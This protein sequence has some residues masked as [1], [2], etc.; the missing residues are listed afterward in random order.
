MALD[1]LFFTH[2]PCHLTRFR[3]FFFFNL[4]FPIGSWLWKPLQP[5]EQPN[6]TMTPCV[7]SMNDTGEFSP[8]TAS[9]TSRGHLTF[10]CCISMHWNPTLIIKRTYFVPD[11]LRSSWNNIPS[12]ES[13]VSIFKDSNLHM[14]QTSTRSSTIRTWINSDPIKPKFLCKY[15]RLNKFTRQQ[16]LKIRELPH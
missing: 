5:K 14:V 11:D 15:H 4:F 13:G 9:S 2:Y 7:Q 1:R 10:R 3:L 12:Q 16:W 6:F 8:R